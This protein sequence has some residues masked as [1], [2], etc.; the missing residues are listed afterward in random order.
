MVEE[1]KQTGLDAPFVLF[2]MLSDKVYF[3]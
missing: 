1:Q 3:L 2:L